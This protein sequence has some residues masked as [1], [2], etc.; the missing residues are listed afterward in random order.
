MGYSLDSVALTVLLMWPVVESSCGLTSICLNLF[1]PH[2]ATDRVT[3]STDCVALFIA[4]WIS[5]KL[6]WITC[7]QEYG[8]YVLVHNDGSCQ[9]NNSI[10]FWNWP[11]WNWNKVIYLADF[12]RVWC[13]SVCTWLGL[14]MRTRNYTFPSE[15]YTVSCAIASVAILG[16]VPYASYICM[17]HC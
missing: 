12:C 1:C 2:W 5:S 14:I 8:I 9:W 6:G 13:F 4:C 7:A 11:Q 17:C 15:H 16:V 10:L 3:S